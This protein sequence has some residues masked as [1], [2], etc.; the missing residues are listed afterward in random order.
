[1]IYRLKNNFI[2]NEKPGRHDNA[3]KISYATQMKKY[4]EKIA[5]WAGIT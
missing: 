4:F 5:P 2:N 1:L 3:R